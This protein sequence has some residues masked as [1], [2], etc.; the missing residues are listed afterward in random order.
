VQDLLADADT[1]AAPE[2]HGDLAE[3]TFALHAIPPRERTGVLAALRGLADAVLI[4]EFDVPP[5]DDRGPAHLAYL[6]TRYELGL[7]EY[8]GSL[9]AQGFLMPVLAGQVDPDRPRLTWEQRAAGWTA[10]LH[11][12]GWDKVAV[13]PLA[14]YWWAPAIVITARAH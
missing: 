10:Q 4:V 3:A 2:R 1:V 6:A 7:A 13:E 9:V 5:F 14:D 11:D 8:E 12:A